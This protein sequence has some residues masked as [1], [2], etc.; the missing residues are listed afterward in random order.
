[1]GRPVVA[2]DHGAARETVA[3]DTGWLAAP[4]DAG[5]LAAAF[6]EALALDAPARHA[7]AGRARRRAVELFA[8]PLM[9]ARTLEVYREL[10]EGRGIARLRALGS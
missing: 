6:D 9:C 3:R 2:S 5:A 4:R 7:L 10:L 8:K 1:M